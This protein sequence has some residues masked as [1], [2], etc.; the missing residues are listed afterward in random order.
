LP[1]PTESIFSEGRQQGS[2]GAAVIYAVAVYTH[3]AGDNPLIPIISAGFMKVADEFLA[4]NHWLRLRG[5]YLFS[6]SKA[7]HSEQ[8]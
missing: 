8:S 5:V 3:I 6:Y 1:K 4:R 2:K 7:Q